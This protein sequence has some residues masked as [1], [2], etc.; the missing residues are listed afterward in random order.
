MAGAHA[1][2]MIERDTIEPRD[3]LMGPQPHSFSAPTRMPERLPR[4][5]G[6]MIVRKIAALDLGDDTRRAFAS[7]LAAIAGRTS[8]HWEIVADPAEADVVFTQFDGGGGE[9]TRWRNT[10]KHFVGIVGPNKVRPL[11]RHTLVHPFRATDVEGVLN[12]IAREIENGQRGAAA[13]DSGI[14]RAWLFPRSL[15]NLSHS[16]QSDHWYCARTSGGDLVWISGDLTSCLSETKVAD[17]LRSG[18]VRL[19]S[20]ASIGA[21]S[22]PPNLEKRPAFELFWLAT[23]NAS[24]ELAP[25]LASDGVFRL[26]RWPDFGQVRVPRAVMQLSA[27]LAARACTREELAQLA[28]ASPQLVNRTLNALSACHLLSVE[29]PDAASGHGAAPSSATGII[30]SLVAGLRKRLGFGA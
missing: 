13:G 25:W 19:E 23:F 7:M 29:A 15:Q 16:V 17:Q 1:A 9:V 27:W 14:D 28:E 10:N 2:R 11:M 21:R 4:K 8:C 24:G 26:R 30:R 3:S 18:Q 20:L 6:I 22:L 12:E 5:E